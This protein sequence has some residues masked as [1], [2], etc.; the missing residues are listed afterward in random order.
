MEHALITGPEAPADG[1]HPFQGAIFDVDG[2]LVDSPHY[3]AW[4]D[5]LQE[6]MC[7]EWSDLRGRTSYA[8]EKF[9]EAVYQQ[10]VAGRPRLAGAR[11]ALEYFGVPDAGCRAELLAAVKQEHLVTLIEAG[12]YTAFGDAIRFVLATKAAGILVAAASSSKNA[13]LLLRQ[14]RLDAYVA[15]P[16]L[17]LLDLLDADVSGRDLPRGKPDP[18]IFLVAAEELPATPARCFVVEDAAVGVLAAKAGGMAA[19]G[20]ARLGDEQALADAGADLVVRTLDEVSRPALAEGRLARK[21]QA[22]RGR[23]DG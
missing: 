8:P 14:V 21:R 6:L 3:R 16:D 23:A 11:A 7:T 9:T 20:V 22:R 13:D 12:E 15:E 2:V 17:T 10:V 4:R 5:A 19:V 18:M 1:P